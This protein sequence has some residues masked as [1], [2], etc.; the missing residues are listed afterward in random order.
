[1]HVLTMVNSLPNNYFFFIWVRSC[2]GQ[3]FW[4]TSAEHCKRPHCHLTRRSSNNKMQVRIA[5]AVLDALSCTDY[6][7]QHGF[8][9]GGSKDCWTAT[10]CNWRCFPSGAFQENLLG[11][12]KAERKVFG[13]H[14]ARFIPF[15]I[16]E[17]KQSPESA[18]S[19]AYGRG[20]HA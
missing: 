18:H 11:W 7:A 12:N 19:K 20:V 5:P 3:I 8:W 17:P 4:E 14:S 15:I 2:W 16:S 1:M 10:I 6:L 13:Q 9:A